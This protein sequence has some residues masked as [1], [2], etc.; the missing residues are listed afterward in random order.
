MWSTSEKLKAFEL[1]FLA[2]APLACVG[3]IIAIEFEWA[4]ILLG[5]LAGAV[6]TWAVDRIKDVR[7]GAEEIDAVA[8]GLYAEVLHIARGALSN[9]SAWRKT[10]TDRKRSN[11]KRLRKFRVPTATMYASASA[12]LSHLPKRTLGLLVAF[13]SAVDDIRRDIAGYDSEKAEKLLPLGYADLF[14]K[15]WDNVCL[16]GVET[17]E[18]IAKDY[19]EA[20]RDRD[21]LLKAYLYREKDPIEIALRDELYPA[22]ILTGRRSYI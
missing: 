5:V 10:V 1:Y 19:P 22:E 20:A 9:R 15:R 4:K 12:K 3:L 13:H 7:S 18:E 8:T 21:H 14:R 11:I 6:T 16:A 17:L 2:L